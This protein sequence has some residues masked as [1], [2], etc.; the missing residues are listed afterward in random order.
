MKIHTCFLSVLFILMVS[1]TSTPGTV[2]TAPENQ[3]P[4]GNPTL[5]PKTSA[6]PRPVST[7][8]V[9]EAAGWNIYHPDSQHLWNRLFRQFYRRMANDGQEYGHNTLDPLLWPETTHLLEGDSYQQALS[10]L[11]EFLA[12]NGE[13]FITDPLKRAILQR[14]LWAVFDWLTVQSVDGY[15]VQRR[16]L[17]QRLAQV[18]QRLALAQPEILSWPANYEAAITSGAFPPAYQTPDL[19][20][21]PPDLLQPE[22]EWVCLGREGGPI[23]MTHTE[24]FPFFGRS[25][26]LIFIRLPEGRQAT[27][28]L[29]PVLNMEEQPPLLPPGTEVALVRQALLIDNKGELTPSPIVESVEL[30]HLDYD[31]IRQG[32]Y[33]FKLDRARLFGGVAGG[34]QPVDEEIP[35]FFS[36]GDVFQANIASYKVDI[37]GICPACHLGAGITESLLSYSRQRFPLPDQQLSILVETTPVREA[38]TVIAWKQNHRTWQ[39]LEGVW[40]QGMR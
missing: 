12:T 28:S 20:F 37:P 10:V 26:F 33:E 31:H 29:L 23:A 16:E 18:I 4:A 34:L 30:R 17:Q 38:E 25:V 15:A 11:D 1:C 3:Q 8:R 9:I 2:G 27:L 6:A 39:V 13:A 32:F 24:E 35:L 5:M 19:G 14:D 21:L 36:H 22:S 40:S 7:D